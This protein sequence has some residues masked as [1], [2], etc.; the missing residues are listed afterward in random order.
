MLEILRA[1]EPILIPAVALT[2]VVWAAYIC[3]ARNAETRLWHE[4]RPR[5]AGTLVM[6]TVAALAIHT[7]AHAMAG[8][9]LPKDRTGI[10][11]PVL[12]TTAIGALAGV[13]S[14]SR[15]SRILRGALLTSLFAL[16]AYFLFSLRMDHFKEWPWDA[17]TDK[18]YA[19]L[20][21]LNHEHDVRQVTSVWMYEGPL[22]FY[23]IA[24]GQENLEP[25][26]S[27]EADRAGTQ[28]YVINAL[29]D[30]NLAGEKRL[31]LVAI[32]P[33]SDALIGIKPELYQALH[34]S[35]CLAP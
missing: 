19:T 10:Y 1:V 22:N 5:L 6:V 9:M 33:G 32:A 21:C 34:N 3:K 20:A 35:P 16:S 13:P 31:Q 24:S 14:F 8:L 17:E 7:A 30:A 18:L 2:A 12:L 28:V 23:R 26:V 27:P 4:A 29:F 15:A 11:I 25:V